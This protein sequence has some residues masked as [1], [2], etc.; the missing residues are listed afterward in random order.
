MNQTRDDI[1]IIGGGIV[2][3]SIAL[4]L[5][6]KGQRVTL[7]EKGRVGEEASGRAGGGVRQQNRHPAERPLAMESVKIWANMK[8]ELDSDVGYRRTG[9]IAVAKSEKEL[10]VL[11]D[12]AKQETAAGLGVEMLTSEEAH[13]FLPDTVDR[14]NI[15]GAKYCVTDGTANPLLVAKAI[16][17]LARRKGVTIKEHE[18]VRRLKTEGGKITAAVTD[19][20]EYQGAVFV[21]AA[22]PWAKGLCTDIGFDYP[23]QL[24]KARLFVTEK[25]PRIVEPFVMLGHEF[26]YRQTIEGNIH[27]GPLSRH[28]TGSYD[29]TSNLKD[30]GEVGLFA[31]GS[32]S[33]LRN[34]NIIRSF[35]GVINFTPDGIAILD[36]VPNFDNLFLTT[37]FCGHGFCLGPIVGKLISEWIVDG[38]SSL[39]LSALK[40][41]R[42]EGLTEFKQFY[43]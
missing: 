42:F 14:G 40:C 43:E 25:L 19:S 22:G 34:V 1:I 3:S 24:Q 39:D 29:K 8:D 6:E 38:K 35:S 4:R 26:Y 11:R 5:A 23:L 7:L 10:E 28:V 17:R 32:L 12:I 27:V 31:S 13:R 2:G 20:G 16:C 33:F 15:Y 30:F 21:N 9:H 18:P 36:K 37:A 41:T